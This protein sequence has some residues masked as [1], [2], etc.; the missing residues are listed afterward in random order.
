[1]K[2]IITLIAASTVAFVAVAQNQPQDWAT[3]YQQGLDA[4]KAGDWTAA[5]E[6]FLAAKAVRPND[7]PK[8]SRVED[9]K[10]WRGGAPYSPNFAAAYST[11]RQALQTADNSERTALVMQASRE[12]EA[13]INQRQHSPETYY[14]LGQCYVL[15]RNMDKQQSL[16]KK[17][18]GTP[19]NFKVDTE[20]MVPEEANAA[21]QMAFANLSSAPSF[22]VIKAEDLNKQPDPE[23]TVVRPGITGQVPTLATK[24]ALIIG[25][26]ES[27]LPGG[28]IEFAASDAVLLRNAIVQYAGYSEANI[29]MVINGTAE[30]IRLAAAALAERMPSGAT[31]MLYYTGPG[32][33]IDGK[34]YLPGVDTEFDTDSS[35]M[36]SKSDLLSTFIEKGARIF[37]FYQT[38]RPIKNGQYFGKDLSVP[39]SYSQMM[40]CIHGGTV[41]SLVRNEQRVGVFTQAMIDVF[42]SFRNNQIRIDDFGW[43]VFYSM[44]RGGTGTEVGS[45]PQTPTIPTLIFLAEDAKF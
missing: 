38:N 31:L 28:R 40:S 37:S 3:P 36:V 23:S 2:P 29:D 34:D 27:R 14:T 5:R 20:V 11:Y 10:V 17:M 45:S 1:M 4:A 16:V 21:A 33:N 35:S 44:K 30:E 9:N 8:S 24:Y 13:L 39:G 25:Q 42:E 12:F 18:Q 6:G 26:G 22:T 19:L 41:Y 7:D 32:V 15:L 43:Q